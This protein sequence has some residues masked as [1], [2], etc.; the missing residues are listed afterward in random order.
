MILSKLADPRLVTIRRIGSLT[1]EDHRLLAIWAAR[2]WVHSEV[3]HDVLT[4][5]RRT[6]DGGGP[7]AHRCATV[8][9]LLRRRH[10][11]G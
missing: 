5:R 10:S 8:R 7:T 6:C 3:P 4:R 11:G 1:N 2:V 9:C